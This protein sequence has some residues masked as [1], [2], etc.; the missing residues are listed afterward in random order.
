MSLTSVGAFAMPRWQIGVQPAGMLSWVMMLPMFLIV[1]EMLESCSSGWLRL[2]SK[3]CSFSFTW[4]T[5]ETGP[6]GTNCPEA[7]VLLSVVV[8]T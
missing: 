2:V 3:D 4:S 7:V 6:V 5:G 8:A 1:I